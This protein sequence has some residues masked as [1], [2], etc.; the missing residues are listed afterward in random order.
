MKRIIAVM[1]ALAIM[2]CII[3]ATQASAYTYERIYEGI[4]EYFYL[5]KEDNVHKFL[6]T[7]Q[8]SG[9]FKFFTI[10]NEDT[11]VYCVDENGNEKAFDDDNGY[12]KNCGCVVYL[13]K[14]KD[15]DFIVSQY[16]PSGQSVSA[17]V[18]RMDMYVQ[19]IDT[20]K[21]KDISEIFGV[22]SRVFEFVPQQDDYY[23]FYSQG[24]NISTLYANL[25]DS[26]FNYIDTDIN[27][28]EGEHFY[29]AA[30]LK[31]GEKYY[32]E[33]THC[34]EERYEDPGSIPGNATYPST[35]LRVGIKKT[36]IASQI[37]VTKY[38]D[39]MTYY[40]D[41]VSQM[42]DYR[43]L[44]AEVIFTD[45]R[46]EKY[47]YNEN[48][49]IVGT[50]VEVGLSSDDQGK[51]F[52]YMIAGYAYTQFY[53]DVPDIKA[54]SLILITA[55]Q[56]VYV[57]G[58][59]S[60]VYPITDSYGEVIAYRFRPQNLKGLSFAVNFSDGTQ[61][62]YTDKDYTLNVNAIDGYVF[63]IKPIEI[64]GGGTYQIEFNYLGQSM[65]Y[66]VTVLDRIATKGDVDRDSQVSVMDAT[67][68][69]MHLASVVTLDAA[70]LDAANVLYDVS[71]LRT[72][73]IL[74]VTHLQKY[75]AGLITKL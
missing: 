16:D 73:D 36:A 50:T 4:A 48:N 19:S 44:E 22:R 66:D 1:I 40:K 64:K 25:Y 65:K 28:G 74:D 7:P 52:V 61:K 59:D 3:P 71:N 67:L 29:L 60:G 58:V 62:V 30:Y 57:A 45:G 24:D 53:L 17:M 37:K 5:K 33:A 63:S 31:A 20:E 46:V 8:Y 72:V 15:Y 42:I 56:K 27:S 38:P 55:P 34:D 35:S 6:F 54:E 32:F 47:S 41:F 14:D 9:Y 39:R 12:N 43:G 18:V 49:E 10:G 68:I 70:Q 69:Q 2:L 21:R 23:A 11:Y 13:E 26:D 51:H 75:V